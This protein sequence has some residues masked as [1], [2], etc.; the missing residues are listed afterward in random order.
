MSIVRS[1]GKDIGHGLH[2]RDP[3]VKAKLPKPEDDF[4]RK[5]LAD[6]KR[7]GWA[8][9]GIEEDAEGPS[10]AFSVGL[11]HT[12]GHPEVI[13]MGLRVPIAYRFINDI[14][15]AVRAGR[16]FE[17]GGRYDEI[18]EGLPLAFVAVAER[19]YR[20]YLGYARW[21]YQG[22]KFPVLQ[23]VWPDKQGVF[24]WEPG[25]DG[26][27]F[28]KQPVLGPA[29]DLTDGWVFPDPPNVATIT[30]RQIIHEG[31]PVLAVSHD[32]KDGAWQ[33][34]TGGPCKQ[35][36]GLVV[37]LADMVRR[38]PSL[39][40]LANLPLGWRAWRAA[41]GQPWQREPKRKGG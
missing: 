25:F 17:T 40:E 23:C 18:A 31:H 4:D 29:R 39:T 38:D 37:C 7:V 15:T 19:H 34:H 6:I 5:L 13:L 36:D 24:P 41:A 26:R 3:L 35:A 16:R 20:E 9:I 1:L 14:G 8:V 10:F 28:Q 2:R 27:F 30:V 11:F 21:F 12:L 32:D 33:F 22:S